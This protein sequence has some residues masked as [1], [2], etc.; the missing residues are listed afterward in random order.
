MD[1]EDQKLIDYIDNNKEEICTLVRK[2]VSIP[3]VNI[4][5]EKVG[6]QLEIGNY[7]YKKFQE[8]GLDNI[9]FQDV[10][11]GARNVLG[12]TP[13]SSRKIG[14]IFNGHTDTVH[15]ENMTIDPFGGSVLDGKIYGRGTADMKS[16]LAAAIIA[17]K[18]ILDLNITLSKRILL[19]AVVDEESSG[20]G[21]NKL[22]SENIKAEYGIVGEPTCY[23]G[24]LKIAITHKGRAELEVTVKGKASH[25][26]APELGINAIS[27]MCDVIQAIEK[28]L[29]KKLSINSHP[30][31]GTATINVGVINGGTQSNIV[32]DTCKIKID[33]RI[34][35]GEN[36]EDVQTEIEDILKKLRRKDPEL[37]AS[38][39]ITKGT[40]D[41]CS[42]P[43]EI[44]PDE[45][46]VKAAISAVEQIIG[47]PAIIWG[48]PGYTDASPLVNK[49]KIPTIVLG[50]GRVG[51]TQDEH[52][53]IE[54][55][56]NCAKVY[57]LIMK[58]ICK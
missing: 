46:I 7:F 51:H 25:G 58:S 45:K 50:P 11:P 15:I 54:E 3:S 41:R 42:Q 16:G 20:R 48:S 21:I 39:R 28:E 35:P 18:A 27:K 14:I 10:Y 49:A 6:K 53:H 32:P 52:V 19:T 55:V 40:I 17:V 37:N 56:V 4:P 57:A 33:R 36:F 30:L 44:S 24:S 43:M 29:P 13:A 1:N 12:E 26:C 8:I 38:V 22:I 9:H 2:L 5:G 34:L 31:L 47:T 23:G